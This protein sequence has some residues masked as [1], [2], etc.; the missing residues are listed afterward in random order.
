MSPVA[1]PT[2]TWP[3]VVTV[4][5]AFFLAFGGGVYA[6]GVQAERVATLK[7]RVDKMEVKIDTILTLSWKM[8]A[9]LGILDTD[10]NLP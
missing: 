4:V 10:I 7:E 8:A 5:L 3:Q 2:T 9:K 6:Y 1:K